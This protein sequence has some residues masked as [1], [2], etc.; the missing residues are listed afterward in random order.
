MKNL[1]CVWRAPV[2]WNSPIFWNWPPKNIPDQQKYE[3]FRKLQK[4]LNHSTLVCSVH[5]TD[6]GKLQIQIARKNI[7]RADVFKTASHWTRWRCTHCTLVVRSLLVFTVV[8]AE[9]YWICTRE[10]SQVKSLKLCTV[11]DWMQPS[12]DH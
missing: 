2:R 5:T 3:A 7:I 10:C 1:P 12:K 6:R 9:S 11:L 8:S 4:V